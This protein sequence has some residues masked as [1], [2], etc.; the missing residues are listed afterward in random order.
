M[1]LKGIGETLVYHAI[2][3]LPDEPDDDDDE[4]AAA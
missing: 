2:V 3:D 4:Q 1:T